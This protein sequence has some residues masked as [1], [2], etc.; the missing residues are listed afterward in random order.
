MD[1]ETEALWDEIIYDQYVVELGFEI[2]CVWS[3]F[4]SSSDT[5]ESW[6][7]ILFYFLYRT[8]SS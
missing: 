6:N 7:S 8:T 4:S 1:E 3:K 2:T 5:R